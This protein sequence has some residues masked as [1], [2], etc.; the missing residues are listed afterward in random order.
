MPAAD[1]HRPLLDL[2]ALGGHEL[3]LSKGVETHVAAEEALEGGGQ[4]QQPGAF[5]RGVIEA[6]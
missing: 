2:A 3:Q 1:P 5:E 4:R 6:E